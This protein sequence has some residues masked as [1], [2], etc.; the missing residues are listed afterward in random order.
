MAVTTERGRI[1]DDDAL[2]AGNEKEDADG[3]VNTGDFFSVMNNTD[4]IE[5][6][7]ILYFNRVNK[8]KRRVL[9]R[10]RFFQQ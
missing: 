5:D 3:D 6:A 10:F 1:L 8:R 7:F 4:L 2:T 9:Q